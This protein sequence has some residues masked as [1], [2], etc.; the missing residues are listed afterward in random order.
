MVQNA[1]LGINAHIN[2]DLPRA[3]A[4][5]LDP[6]DLPN[7]EIM[8]KRKFDHDQVN[9][10]LVRTVNPVQRVLAKNYEPGIA[11]F[12]RVLGGFDERACGWLLRTYR[13]QVWWNALSFAAAEP[14][15][16]QTIVR[17]KLEWESNHLAK[18]APRSRM[19]G[20]ER[21]VNRAARVVIRRALGGRPAGAAL[22]RP[23]RRPGRRRPLGEIGCSAPGP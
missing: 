22:P 7:Y 15:D 6:A 21:A 13:E 4:A 14:G 19:W 2:F 20:A 16:E 23:P 9:N 17:N 5:N 1:L 18:S 11:V 10:L 8:Q 12:D 3:I